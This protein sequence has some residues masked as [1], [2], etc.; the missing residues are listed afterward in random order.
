MTEHHWD[1]RPGDEDRI[2]AHLDRQRGLNLTQLRLDDGRIV[3]VGEDPDGVDCDPH[4]P[5]VDDR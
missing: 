1:P 2:R 4:D 5:D 3:R